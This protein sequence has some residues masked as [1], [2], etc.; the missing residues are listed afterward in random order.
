MLG[1][2]K[3]VS[4]AP[5]ELRSVRGTEPDPARCADR[6]ERRDAERTDRVSGKMFA[7]GTLE[8][9]SSTTIHDKH[10]PAAVVSTR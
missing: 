8:F 1:A 2:R 6:G 7:G 9:R 3:Y 10:V 4:Y 5:A